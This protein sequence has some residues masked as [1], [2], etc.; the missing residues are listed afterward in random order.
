MA[1]P[2]AGEL[3]LATLRPKSH[4]TLRLLFEGGW[5][6]LTIL[7]AVFFLTG[8]GT[9]FLARYLISTEK[10]YEREGKTVQATVTRKDTY[11][12]R[13][14]SGSGRHRHTRTRTHYRVH[15]TFRSDDGKSHSG[16][17]NVSHSLWSS[18]DPGRPIE[19][20]YLPGNPSKNRPAAAKQGK[21]VW[22]FL[23]FPVIFG[24][25]GL[26]MLVI[27]GRRAARHG[28]LLTQGN[29]TRGTV[30]EKTLRRDIRINNRSPYAISYRFESADGG[31]HTG[32]DLVLDEATAARLEPGQPVGV[33][34][35][36]THP[37][38]CTLFRE[39]WMKYFQQT[40]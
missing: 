19:V 40:G 24:G 9:V 10:R 25:A 13:S 8:V 18:L 28:T 32:K 16:R 20:Q 29:L 38:K 22:V 35:L 12:T 21:T 6:V 34:Y 31:T 3:N 36:P 15:Y 5:S 2:P 37:D 27:V 39:K 33:L 23:L 7:G 1:T 17:G 26:V 4:L 14:T 30:E 11:T